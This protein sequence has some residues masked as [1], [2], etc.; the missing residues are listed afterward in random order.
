MSPPETVHASRS[1]HIFLLLH[2]QL[3]NIKSQ[4]LTCRHEYMQC[5][6]MYETYLFTYAF[7]ALIFLSSAQGCEVYVRLCLCVCV[8]SLGGWVSAEAA[9]IKHTE[10]KISCL[11]FPSLNNISHEITSNP[12]VL[13]FIVTPICSNQICVCNCLDYVQKQHF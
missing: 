8:G 11:V 1:T 6:L 5:V 3:Y 2:F 12:T 13:L 7:A 4:V 9:R 10:F